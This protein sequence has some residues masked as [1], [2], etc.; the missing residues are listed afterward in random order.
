MIQNFDNIGNVQTNFEQNLISE[1]P[2]LNLTENL[3]SEIPKFHA[4]DSFGNFVANLE[5]NLNNGKQGVNITIKTND[6][7]EGK[8]SIYYACSVCPANF[9]E[10]S[11]LF[12]HFDSMH[13]HSTQSPMVYLNKKPVQLQRHTQHEI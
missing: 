8:I 5:G 1:E 7:N 10:K 13:E 9:F 2:V 12:E 6:Q 11:S 4:F 3:P